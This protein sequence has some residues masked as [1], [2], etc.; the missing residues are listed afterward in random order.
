MDRNNALQILNEDFKEKNEMVCSLENA[1]RTL[2]ELIKDK[3]FVI[4]SQNE[5]LENMKTR[6]GESIEEMTQKG[7]CISNGKH[8][9]KQI[10]ELN[11]MREELESTREKMEGFKVERKNLQCTV[12]DKKALIKEQSEKM[13]S[14]HNELVVIQ[15]EIVEV[16]QFNQELKQKIE[17]QILLVNKTD[18]A[19]NAK[20][21]L[22]EVK[23]EII[24]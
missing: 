15:E 4:K 24:T 13:D 11:A 5:V 23:K 2:E 20:E 14:L 19:F 1:N 6:C 10:S 9:G 8:D 22:V 18:I 17:D 12:Q 21:E 16:K 3:D 7:D